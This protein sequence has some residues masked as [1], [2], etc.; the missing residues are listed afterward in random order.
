M[1]HIQ[2]QDLLEKLD[3]L[4]P[5]VRRDGEESLDRGD[6]RE[7]PDLLDQKVRLDCLAQLVVLEN[8]DSVVKLDSQENQAWQA[9]L[10]ILDLLDRKDQQE[11]GVVQ[12]HLEYPDHVE[13]LAREDLLDPEVCSQHNVTHAKL[14]IS[15]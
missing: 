3:P 13:K 12:D 8:L 7:K 11:R 2:F 15:R 4:V 9:C 10:E 1:P 6:S 14:S 5:L